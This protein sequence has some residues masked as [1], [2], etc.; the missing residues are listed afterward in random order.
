MRGVLLGN[1][2]PATDEEATDVGRRNEPAHETFALLQHLSNPGQERTHAAP[3]GPGYCGTQVAAET[4]FR[5]AA[6]ASILKQA[7]RLDGST[8]PF[9][10]FLRSTGLKS[11]PLG[12]P[13]ASRIYEEIRGCND[14]HLKLE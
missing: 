12:N 3:S 2:H 1:E 11:N 10:I 14:L 13:V 6:I 4:I 9:K 5:R 8:R 7:T